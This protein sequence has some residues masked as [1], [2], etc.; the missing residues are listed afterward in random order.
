MCSTTQ[1]FKK[2]TP[3]LLMAVSISGQWAIRCFECSTL[4]RHPRIAPDLTD[5]V[6]VLLL[7]EDPGGMTA[8]LWDQGRTDTRDST[9]AGARKRLIIGGAGPSRSIWMT[10]AAGSDNLH[11]GGASGCRALHHQVYLGGRARG[12]HAQI[13]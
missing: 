8:R 7:F 5:Q 3:R 9:C 11:S 4:P 1:S 13:P 10:N 6:A 2:S 12:V